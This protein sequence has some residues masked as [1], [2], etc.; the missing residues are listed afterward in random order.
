MRVEW[1]MCVLMGRVEMFPFPENRRG[2]EKGKG[3][4]LVDGVSLLWQWARSTPCALLKISLQNE[5]AAVGQLRH[6]RAHQIHHGHFLPKQQGKCSS[7]TLRMLSPPQST[8]TVLFKCAGRC[9][10]RCNRLTSPFV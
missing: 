3:G 10:N 4:H 8:R 7:H 9:L 1:E 2:V 5:Q 6:S